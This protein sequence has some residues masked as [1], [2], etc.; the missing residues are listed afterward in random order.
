MTTENN[1]PQITLQIIG[2]GDAFSQTLGSSSYCFW[3][4]SEKNEAVLFDCGFQT[5]AHLFGAEKLQSQISTIVISHFHADHVF[6][7]PVLLAYWCV[8][9]P[10]KRPLRILGPTG[11]KKYVFSLCEA[12]YPGVINRRKFDIEFEEITAHHSCGEFEF[13]FAPTKHSVE[14]YALKVRSE[15]SVFAF[16]GD[17]ALTNESLELYQGASWLVHEAFGL[18]GDMPKHEF[19]KNLIEKLSNCK[20]LEHL[21]V[22]HMKEE[23]H[24][25]SEQYLLEIEESCPFT[26]KLIQ[27]NETYYL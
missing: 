5:P 19:L 21:L 14:S 17:G 10:R 2:C 15:S 6:G 16:S 18:E 12:A 13:F 24:P 26:T 23:E 8:R 3:N 22:T 11:V 7:L 9:Q 27:P 25:S 20:S 4:Q 1:N